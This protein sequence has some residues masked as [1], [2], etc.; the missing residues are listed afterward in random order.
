MNTDTFSYTIYIEFGESE[1]R[2]G[3]RLTQ[4]ELL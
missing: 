4:L 2:M 1:K 3:N